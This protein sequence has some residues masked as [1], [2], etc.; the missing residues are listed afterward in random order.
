M[1]KLTKTFND[2]INKQV[3]LSFTPAQNFF[4]SIDNLPAVQFTVQQIQIP[5]VN[6]GEAAVSNRMNPG[7]SYVP[8]ESLDYSTLDVTFLLDKEFKAYRSILAWIKGINSADDTSQIQGWTGDLN[9]NMDYSKTMSNITVFGADAGM[10]PLYHWDFKGAFP[11]SL[12]GPQFDST[13]PDIEYISATVSFRYSYFEHQTY[14]A[15]V[16]NDDII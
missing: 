9:G 16:A 14:T 5:P 10:N 3:E 12:D 1:A 8:G 13:Q 6:G 4:M 7:K 15:G 11:V 2:V